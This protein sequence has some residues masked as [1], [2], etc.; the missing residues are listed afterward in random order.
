MDIKDKTKEELIIELQELKQE[1]SVLKA[2]IENRS[3]KL[4]TANEELILQ[5]EG[6]TDVSLLRQK[7]EKL[8]KMGQSDPNKNFSE[9]ELLKLIHELEVHQI[10]LGLQNEELLLAKEQEEL[11]REKFTSLFDFAPSAYFTLNDSSNIAEL[12]LAGAQMLGKERQKLINSRL[13]LFMSSS[14]QVVFDD[15]LSQVFNRS[16]PASCEVTFSTEEDSCINALLEGTL[17][18]DGKHCLITA[19]DITNI[20]RRELEFRKTAELNYLLLAL[21]ANA[22]ALTDKQLYDEALDIAVKVT[23]SAIGFFH[24]VS[25]DQQEIILTTWNDEARKNCSTVYDNHYPI[26]KAGNWADCVRQKKPVVYNDDAGSPNRKGMPAGHAPV[27]R[28][29]SVPV[30]HEE[31]VRLIFGVGNKKSD[32]TDADVTFIQSIANELDKILGKR[33]IERNLQQI[34][35]RWHFAIEGSNDGIWDWNVLTGDVHFSNRWK[36]MIG[37]EPHEIGEKLEEWE[38]RVHP[39]DMPAVQETLQRHFNGESPQYLTEHRILCKDGSWKWIQDRGKVLQ[40][41]PEGKPMRMVG[42][43]T[44]ITGR[45]L[46]EEQIIGQNTLINGI[47]NATPNFLVLKNTDGTYREVNAVFC[48]FV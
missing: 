2:L 32:Y 38:K 41:T 16:R 45:K 10:E 46:A 28:T 6:I 22:P 34:E 21:F 17:S 19:A 26:D 42:T 27:G 29:M 23:G 8:L 1:N 37:F 24:Q 20:N 18:D 31:K 25:D 33:A 4:I 39:D 48:I 36:E 7:A 11:A 47:L 12:N 44:D 5:N 43:H 13:T 3:A 9:D 15:F 35:D 14:S 40:W 30:V